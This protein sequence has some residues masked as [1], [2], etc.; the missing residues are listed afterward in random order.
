MAARFAM[1]RLSSKTERSSFSSAGLESSAKSDHSTA[2]FEVAA[3][4]CSRI[5]KRR[6]R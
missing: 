1:S 4:T 5:W 2:A 3:A 6:V